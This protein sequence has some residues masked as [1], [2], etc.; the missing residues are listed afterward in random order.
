MAK[1]RESAYVNDFVMFRNA[2]EDRKLKNTLS[3]IDRMKINYNKQQDKERLFFAIQHLSVPAHRK[4]VA[5]DNNNTNNNT[6]KTSSGDGD[7]IGKEASPSSPIVKQKNTPTER[8]DSRIKEKTEK[9]LPKRQSSASASSPIHI[10]PSNTEECFIGVRN[11]RSASDKNT[12]PMCFLTVEPQVSTASGRRRRRSST[13]SVKSTRSSVSSSACSVER[14]RS[15]RSV[16][17]EKLKHDRDKDLLSELINRKKNNKEEKNHEANTLGL[18]PLPAKKVWEKQLGA[19]KPADKALSRREQQEVARRA[20]DHWR[21]SFDNM[22]T[23]RLSSYQSK[24]FSS[25]DE[26]DTTF[27]KFLSKSQQ[28][29][30]IKDVQFAQKFL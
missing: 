9:L 19:L 13:N 14:V 6:N 18:N 15:P 1:F 30:Y 24:I 29:F 4:F 28:A 12:K 25:T 16:T 7:L 20:R 21:A 17:E 27:V 5:P 11:G 10:V 26:K 8:A 2:C 3:N 23:R 22:K